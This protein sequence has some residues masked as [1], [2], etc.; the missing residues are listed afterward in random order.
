MSRKPRFSVLHALVA[1]NCFTVRALK[2]GSMQCSAKPPLIAENL[3]GKI[4]RAGGS[5]P[6]HLSKAE[7]LKNAAESVQGSQQKSV[8]FKFEV[9]TLA[10][11]FQACFYTF[12][13]H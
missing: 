4:G 2:L 6:A 11:D 9:Q 13:L 1:I 7:Q 5:N 3:S 10:C 8:S 12:F